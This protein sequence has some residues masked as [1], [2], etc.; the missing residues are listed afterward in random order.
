MKLRDP[1]HR[2]EN[3]PR[4]QQADNDA[5]EGMSSSQGVG[6]GRLKLMSQEANNSLLRLRGNST[7]WMWTSGEVK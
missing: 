7:D 6:Q 2:I 4:R 1:I 3:S 5:A